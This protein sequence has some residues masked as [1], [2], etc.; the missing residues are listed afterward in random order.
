M[1][2]SHDETVASEGCHCNQKLD[3]HS[4]TSADGGIDLH[5]RNAVCSANIAEREH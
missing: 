5:M 2:T 4:R 3:N 1:H